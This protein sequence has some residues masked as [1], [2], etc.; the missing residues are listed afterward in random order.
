MAERKFRLDGA[1]ST[2]TLRDRA[3]VKY[4]ARGAALEEELEAMLKLLR[5]QREKVEQTMFSGLGYKQDTG[6]DKD[7]IVAAKELSLGYSRLTEAQ[8]KLNK[9]MK[10]LA[11]TLTP[12]EQ[13]DA[14]RQ[15]LRQ[16]EP[17]KLADF[18][19]VEIK[20]YNKTALHNI[21]PGRLVQT[22]NVPVVDNSEDAV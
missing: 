18:L 20:Q 16:M 6:I 15:F 8:I 22:S 12:E 5:F 19:D 2:D 3:L 21:N 10:E 4:N 13:I 7:S 11:D 17:G 1:P 9:S 14:V